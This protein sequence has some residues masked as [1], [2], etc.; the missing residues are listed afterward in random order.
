MIATQAITQSRK[1]S[2]YEDFETF[3][4]LMYQQMKGKWY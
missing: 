2:K 1:Q 3:D 4:Y